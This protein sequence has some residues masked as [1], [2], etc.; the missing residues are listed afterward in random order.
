MENLMPIAF[1][2]PRPI[3]VRACPFTMQSGTKVP[4]LMFVSSV[5]SRAKK[6]GVHVQF[7]VIQQR[8]RALGHG[9]T[10]TT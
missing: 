6:R 5:I 9:R 2:N 3:N 10:F 4:F 8:N 7:P 1:T